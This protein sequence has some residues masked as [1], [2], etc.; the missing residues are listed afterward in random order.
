M[1]FPGHVGCPRRVVHGG[2]ACCA[3]VGVRNRQ[4]PPW[5]I[6][7]RLIFFPGASRLVAG[8]LGDGDRIL[9]YRAKSSYSL[10]I[11]HLRIDR[12]HDRGAA[13]AALASGLHGGFE[14][15][16]VLPGI[17]TCRTADTRRLPGR[18]LVRIHAQPSRDLFLAHRNSPE[19]RQHISC[20]HV[21]DR[22]DSHRMDRALR[23]EA[24]CRHFAG[25]RSVHLRRRTF[26]LRPGGAGD[27]GDFSW[28]RGN[29]LRVARRPAHAEC[30]LRDC[31][32]RHFRSLGGLEGPCPFIWTHDRQCVAV[33]AVAELSIQSLAHRRSTFLSR[34]RSGLAVRF[35]LA[36]GP[37]ERAY[38][39]A[40]VP[41]RRLDLLAG[42]ERPNRAATKYEPPEPSRPV[43]SVH[44]AHRHC[45]I[46]HPC[47]SPGLP[48]VRVPQAH[49]F[50][51]RRGGWWRRMDNLA[52]QRQAR[53]R[54]GSSA[55]ACRHAGGVVGGMCGDIL[56][57]WHRAGG[58]AGLDLELSSAKADVCGT[59]P[60]SSIQGLIHVDSRRLSQF[61]TSYVP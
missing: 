50:A 1:A 55:G 36:R 12:E 22:R 42:S 26:H 58:K 4:R 37:L 9:R 30:D 2:F 6:C 24:P 16:V 32:G 54:M 34:V 13:G 46:F 17:S 14:L 35:H 19:S 47:L 40:F 44:S 20:A 29:L 5:H 60:G 53:T 15:R 39:G 27:D 21:I 49:L 18:G 52:R 31:R 28:R 10:A 33:R 38:G 51:E 7:R 59:G 61:R 25:R 41:G 48:L 57:R 56:F 3:A 23:L 11:F 8:N 45:A 43:V